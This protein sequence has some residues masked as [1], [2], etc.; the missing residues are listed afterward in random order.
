MFDKFIEKFVFLLVAISTIF[1]SFEKLFFVSGL[2][3]RTNFGGWSDWIQGAM[4]SEDS[5]EIM[6]YCAMLLFSTLMT[7]LTIK[8]MAKKKVPYNN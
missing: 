5:T 2:D 6:V 4:E 1:L 8:T 7:L 3:S